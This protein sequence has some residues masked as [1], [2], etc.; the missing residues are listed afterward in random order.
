MG[1]KLELTPIQAVESADDGE[2]AVGLWLQGGS[3][4]GEVIEPKSG[5]AGSTV[6]EE[7]E[8]TENSV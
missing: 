1:R 4:S 5:A 8:G 3:G 7:A 2:A 6:G